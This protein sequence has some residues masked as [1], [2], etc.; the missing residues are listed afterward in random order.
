MVMTGDAAAGMPRADG[1]PAVL[2]M[3]LATIVPAVM[4]TGPANVLAPLSASVPVPTLMMPEV[5]PTGLE[6]MPDEVTL[7]ARVSTVRLEVVFSSE[8]GRDMLN[9][10]LNWKVS[11]FPAAP[12]VN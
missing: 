1:L 7:F 11:V 6:M 3:L 8:I 5:V 2:P 12:R 4:V 9:E 10:P